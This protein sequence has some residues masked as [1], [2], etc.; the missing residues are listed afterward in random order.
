[1]VLNAFVSVS[2]STVGVQGDLAVAKAN[3]R[4]L[5]LMRKWLH[6]RNLP[7][8]W[9]WVLERGDTLGLHSH[10]VVCVPYDYKEPFAHWALRA[11]QTISRQPPVRD[12]RRKIWTVVVEHATDRMVYVQWKLFQ[13]VMKGMHPGVLAKNPTNRFAPRRLR[14]VAGLK[15]RSQGEISTKRVGVARE[16]DRAAQRRF[17]AEHDG[18]PCALRA[19]A[20]DPDELYTDLYLRWFDH[21]EHVQELLQTLN[22]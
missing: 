17:W 5:E 18:P 16:I 8:A 10:L 2:W 12:R 4:L 7:K 13:Y 19:G 11:V 22:I 14:T 6:E 20:T 9:F 15:L 1:L 21:Q 3:E